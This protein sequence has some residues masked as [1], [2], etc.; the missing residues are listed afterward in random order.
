MTSRVS[1]ATRRISFTLSLLVLVVLG[2]ALGTGRKSDA[3]VSGNRVSTDPARGGPNRV[4]TKLDSNGANASQSDDLWTNVSESKSPI[5]IAD[6]EKPR[7]YRILELNETL[8]PRLVAEAPMEFTPQTNKLRT[9]ISLPLPDGRLWRFRIVESPVMSPDFGAKFP[10]I[11]TYS[12]QSID[13]PTATARFS[14]SPRGLNAFV[15]S[16]QGSFVVVPVSTEDQHHYLS[17][18]THDLDARSFECLTGSASSR[19]SEAPPEQ[20]DAAVTDGN[21]RRYRLAVS[22]TPEFIFAVG[23]ETVAGAGTIAAVTNYINNVTAIYEREIGVRFT[24]V[25]VWNPAA[26]GAPLTNGDLGQMNPQ[27]QFFLDN[28]FFGGF[29]GSAS[30]DIGAALGYNQQ[31]PSGLA[32]FGVGGNDGIGGACQPGYKAQASILVSG[33][34]TNDYWGSVAIAHELGHMFGGRHTFTPVTSTQCVP[35]ADPKGMVEPGG[36][37]T[38]MSYAPICGSDILFT[39]EPHSAANSYFHIHSLLKI[40]DHKAFFSACG[41]TTVT[42]NSPPVI[43]N[44][45]VGGTIP[46]LTPFTLTAAATDPNGDPVTYAWEE[47]DPG[48][49][50]FRTYVPSSSPSRTF[51]SLIYILNN[52]NVPPTFISGFFSGEALPPVTGTL[53]F[54][55]TVR[56]N[57][58]GGGGT[59]ARDQLLPVN[60]VGS[61][62]PFKVTQPNTT[63]TLTSGGQTT[64][65]WNVANTNLAPINTSSVRILLSTDGGNTFPTVLAS[66]APNDGS[67][68][69][70]LPNVQTTTARIKIEAVGNI[71]FDISDSDFAISNTLPNLTPYQPNGWSDKIVVSNTPGTNTDSSPLRTTDT[72]YVDWAIINNG[73]AAIGSAFN[74][75]LYV[76]G[77]AKQTFVTNPPMNVSAITS[78]QDYSIGSLSAGTH[79]IRIVADSGGV[80]S[81]T[82]EADNEYTKTITVVGTNQVNVQ[83]NPAGRPFT[84]DGTTYSTTQIFSW[85]TGSTHTIGTTSPQ[86][87]GAGIQY[88]WASWSDGG[89]I[90]HTVSPSSNTT[91]TV[92][93][94]TQYFLTMSAGTGGT[95]SPSSGYF[96][97][98]TVVSISANP[99]S[100]FSFSGWTGSGTGSFTGSTNPVGVTLNGPISQTASFASAP[101]TI[102]FS[103]SSYSINEGDATGR[104]NI[105]LTRSGDTTSSASVNYATN[106][107]AGLTNCNVFNGI[108]SP[109]CDYENTQGTMPFAAGETSKSFSV[110]IVDDSY[111]EGN[112]TFTVGLNSPSGATL[113]AQSTATVTI[114]DNDATTGPNPIDNTNFFVREQYIDFLGRE[115]DPPGL[116]GWTS[117]INNCSGDTTQCDRIHVSQLFF[118]SAEFQDRGYFVYRFYPVAFGRKP[119]YGEF[120]PD[121][122][123]VSGFLD[124]NQL[125]AAKV[126]FIAA[127]MARPAFVSTYNGL[128]NQQYVDALLN[129]AG[130]TLSSR[131]TMINGLNGSTM[132]RAQ[133]LRQI[134]ESTEVSIK[135]NHQAYAVME[136]FGYLR[137]QPD[138]FYLQ[139]IQVLDSTNDPRG[140]VTGFATSP[141]YRNRFGP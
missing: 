86:S 65:T 118:Q 117:T 134:V 91:Y 138:G 88:V 115:P 108:A 94:T 106:D 82:N 64:I 122:A 47:W 10:E 140:M 45:G 58:S 62:G 61:A 17:Y 135:Y 35:Q 85:T 29:S 2:L 18:F 27:N 98:G 74:E 32:S 100:G 44:A 31:G 16:E 70:T 63:V 79:T 83:S 131:Q 69:V 78:F 112:E 124:A 39:N 75:I 80:I 123:S 33:P 126:A 92:N 67:E 23:G 111:H 90:S 130:V 34:S 109:R 139:W 119:D 128:A 12:G 95:V 110:A 105:T 84:V 37:S 36:G 28:L 49:T 55:V 38:I 114:I 87:G 120:V 129:T 141:E 21:L 121:L 59:T 9:L 116:S 113:G 52:G 104:V 24:L 132:T 76:D 42:G 97:S 133:V 103:S 7:A 48:S 77:I 46:A 125:E 19:G 53:N 6:Q 30:Y 137:R 136:Y 41:Q 107:A 68:I 20:P 50:L 89:G 15:I 51:P 14:W 93:F 81:E 56:D 101:T 22:V 96:N 66:N 26:F 13:D 8:F 25:A 127:F 43:T 60:I 73:T 11:K 54:T 3:N 5:Q 99:N 102:Q 72:L 4:L 57:R 1:L 71:Y 40:R